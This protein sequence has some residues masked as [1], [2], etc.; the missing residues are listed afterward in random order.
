MLFK[1]KTGK[2][3]DTGY[4][5]PDRVVRF[6]KDFDKG[7]RTIACHTGTRSTLTYFELRLL[8]FKE[9]A[10]WD[11]SWIVWGSNLKYPVANEQWI[12]FEKLKKAE[13]ELKALKDAM[14][15]KEGAKE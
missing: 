2:D 12:N 14:P 6:Y 1:A 4:I 15:K 8:G 5:S 11:D 13:D 9:P 10:N 3:V 7:K